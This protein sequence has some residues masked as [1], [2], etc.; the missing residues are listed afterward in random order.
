MGRVWEGYGMGGGRV[1]D[2][3]EKNPKNV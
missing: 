3:W 2:G 1:R